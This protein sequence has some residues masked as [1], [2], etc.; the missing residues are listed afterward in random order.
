MAFGKKKLPP[1]RRRPGDRAP[2]QGSAV[3]SYYNGEQ[4]PAADAVPV[5]KSRPPLTRRQKL[6]IV[7]GS[8]AVF[9]LLCLFC[10]TLTTGPVV[11]FVGEGTSPYRTQDVYASSAQELLGASIGSRSKFT[12]NTGSVEKAL[13][14]EFP[15]LS[16]A[17]ISLPIIG[18]RPNLILAARAPAVILTTS[19]KA[20]VLDTT[21]RAVTDVAHLSAAARS[22]LPSVEDSS[23]VEV[24][25]GDQAVTSE[26]VTFIRL[27]LAQ[28]KAKDMA[29]ERLSLPAV[30]N[31]LDVRLKGVGYYIKCDIS[32]DAR[33]QIG[34]YL[35]VRD[36]GV[37]PSEYMDV[38]V[39][40]KVFY[41]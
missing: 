31:E 13:L 15:E 16:A 18:R 10:T 6:T 40:E 26:T 37:S 1:A 35:A 4:A 9:L 17:H 19:S 12:I 34:R 22:N 28:L 30:A 27:A 29:V 36:S 11:S 3:F 24:R 2:A 38:R 25:I 5:R 41:K 7:Y 21:G 20:L 39:E 8:V 33:Q 23:T 32:G 14:D